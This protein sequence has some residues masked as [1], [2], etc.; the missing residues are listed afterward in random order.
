MNKH[1]KFILISLLILGM[2]CGVAMAAAPVL[3]AG[4]VAPGSGDVST[5]FVFTVT[6][7]DADND[8]AT[9][10][11]VNIDGVLYNMTETNLADI[12]STDGKGYTHTASGF[13]VATHNFNFSASDG[14]TPVGPSGAG[15]FSVLNSAPTIA[16]SVNPSS[17]SGTDTFVFTATFTDADND[18]ASFAN[19][20]IDGA[21][22]T[23]TATDAGDITTT[24]GK[25]YSYS[26]SGF[27]TATHSYQFFASDGTVAVGPSSAGT[28]VVNNNPTLTVDSVSPTS[29]TVATIFTFNVTYTDGDNEFPSPIN[30]FI[31]GTS[32]AMNQ[33]DAS[34]TNVT[35]GKLYSY[36][37]GG[38]PVATHNYQFKASDGNVSASDTTLTTFSVV[39]DIP[40]LTSGSVTSNP[41][42]TVGSTFMFNVTYTDNVAT[43]PSYMQVNITGTN[44]GMSKLDPSDVDATDG[45]KYTYTTTS[46]AVGDHNYYFK[47]SD[48]S[49]PINTTTSSVTV[50][51]A[52]Y[53][54][55]DRIWDENAGQSTKYIWDALS[56]S[57]FFYDLESGLGS[58]KMTM[59]DIDRNIGKGDLEYE[60]TPIETD[61]EYG[62]WGSYE[63]I[64]FMAE[65]YFAG[66]TANTSSDVSDKVISLMSKGHLTKVLIDSDDKER[67]YSGSGLVLEEGYVLNVVE[68]DKNGDKIFVSLSKDGDEVDEIVVSSGD[69]YVY[70]KDL[71]DVD[72]VPIIAV[73]FDEIFS[74]TETNAVFI[75]GIFQISDKYEDINTG[76]EYGAMKVKS[77]SSTMIRMENEDT[78]SLDKGDIADIMGKLKFV[79]AD[80]NDLRFAPFVDMSEPGTYELRGTIAEDKG[81]KWTP[82][83]FEGFYYNIDEGIGTESL[84]LTYTGRTIND[85]DLVYTTSPSSVSFEYSGW[86]NYTVIGFMAEKYFVGFPNDPFNDGE[87]SALSL[88]S[89]GQLSKVLIDDDDKKSIFGGSSLILEEG[90]SLDVVEVN[91]DGDKVF[92]ELSKD[93]DEVDEQ[94]LSSGKT[95]TYKKDLGEVDDVPII[96][97]NFKEIFSGTET[98]AVFVEGIFQISDKYEELNTGDDY[99][100]MEIK[101]IS[102]IKIEMKNK[103][104][105][106]LSKGDEVEIM[107]D[108][109]FKVADSSSNVRYYPFVEISTAPADSL[110]VDVDPEVVSEGDKITVTVTSR[111]SLINGVTVKAG[112]IVLGTTDNEGE[113][114]YTFHADGTY[115]ITAE[116][117]DYVTGEAS[118]EVISPDDESRKMSIEISPEVIYEGNLV[119]FTVV[120]SIGGDALEDVDVTIDGKSIGETDSDGVVTYVLKDIGMHKITAEKEGFLEAEDNIEVK[121]LEAKFEFSNLVVTPL[122]VKSGKDVNV[123]LDAVNNGKAAGSYTV[124]LVVNDNTTATQEISLGV[125]ESTQVEFEYTA[126]EPGTYL[127]KV[128]SMTATVEVV[129]GAGAVT[130]LLGGVAIAVLG[131]AVYLFTAGGWTVSTAGAKAGE[132]AATLSEKLSSLLSRGK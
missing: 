26:N 1:F 121:E 38:F 27:S 36:T 25:T 11:D 30:V 55:G 81:L 62:A 96:S 39:S 76:D 43:D 80:H 9:A 20:S 15:T 82:L 23:M 132:A 68:V 118:L 53:F 18:P 73:N 74:G 85:N 16:G 46:L 14:T 120:K 19:V 109:K 79:V 75:E 65:K 35:D 52:T 70:E 2:S 28:F 3:S 131:G 57:G 50:N 72:D 110:D 6:F 116:K 115:T 123:I 64:G 49:N 29:G 107:G 77:I 113:V 12:N 126:G 10:V 41:D 8:T 89:Q 78:I 122:E 60:T 83:N 48:S 63:V 86:D 58:E 13:S 4:I 84:N 24:D 119:T 129:N 130:Y 111:G 95:Y 91:K 45:I 93:G 31:N 54:S 103:D 90:Y 42:S 22:Y 125:G 71:G 97:V 32:Y 40:T 7:T 106:S 99:G 87:V 102:S 104:S 5:P 37:K 105:I 21:N 59:D 108:I 51:T 92:V 112:S 98:N 127:V 67:V 124:E 88:M 69:T 66:Y 117:D 44:Y 94:V 17:G 61:F 34:D 47:A 128:D 56:Y 33:V 100:K 114:D 101:T